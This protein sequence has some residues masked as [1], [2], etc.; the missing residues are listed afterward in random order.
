MEPS[1]FNLKQSVNSYIDSIK[2]Q[3]SITNSDA[4]ELSAHL[5][6]ATDS[7]ISLGLSQEEAFVIACKRLG[8]EEVLTKEYSKVNP[9]IKMNQIWAY[10]IMG[11][12]LFYSLPSLLL[13]GISLLYL[14]VYQSYNSSFTST[15][16]I[17]VFHLLLTAL[18][19]F[20]IRR[21]LEISKFLERQIQ[22]HSLRSVSLSFIPF[23]V[24]IFIK[25][26][27]PLRINNRLELQRALNFPVY[28]FDSDFVEFSFYLAI[29]SMIGAAISLVFSINKIEKLTLK[30]FF[31]RP[32][33]SFLIVFGIILEL[34]AASTRSLHVDIISVSALIFATV[35]F[36]A[37]YLIS[38]YNSN[39]SINKHLVITSLFGVVMETA[40]GINA[41]IDRGNTIYTVYYVSF[42]LVGIVLGK[43]AG[44]M[45][46]RQFRLQEV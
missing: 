18:I 44:L 9:S 4:A 16:I 6:D 12:N 38:F 7:F 26:I 22:N 45:S 11:F 37:S 42:M 31:E 2:N 43:V 33:T 13:L 30:T 10:L 15:L 46:A 14:T 40:V 27:P 41:D 35:Y 23:L 29:L 32:S 21:K 17:T 34:F 3:G 8:N 25:L 39:G 1:T 20:L 28:K 5:Y 24:P 36:S 19:W